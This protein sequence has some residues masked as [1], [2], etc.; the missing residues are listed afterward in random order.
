M[1][2][3]QLILQSCGNSK[4]MVVKL[5][6]DLTECGVKNISLSGTTKNKVGYGNKITLIIKGEMEITNYEI[7]NMFRITKVPELA[8]VNENKSSTAKY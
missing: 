7:D 3:Q 1:S 8:N 2:N 4:L 6:K 5:I